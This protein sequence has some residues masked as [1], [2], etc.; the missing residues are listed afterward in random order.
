[1]LLFSCRT[2]VRGQG[3]YRA[4]VSNARM[5]TG[6]GAATLGL[7]G[8]CCV[9]LYGLDTGAAYEHAFTYIRQLAVLL[10]GA[11]AAKTK[12]AFREV[13]CWQTI[14]S[15]DLWTKIVAAYPDRPVR[16]LWF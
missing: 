5:M 9:E 7:M 10:R 3:V 15:L 6:E 1:M 2:W 14:N 12:D 11:L 4:Y 16:A 13:Y 8:R